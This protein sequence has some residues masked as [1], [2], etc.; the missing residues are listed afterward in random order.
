MDPFDERILKV[1]SD[2]KK[3]SFSELSSIVDFSHKTLRL[4]LESLVDRG[5]VLKE[6]IPRKGHGRPM[7]AYALSP[8]LKRQITHILSEPYIEFVSLPFSK[9]KHLCRFEKGG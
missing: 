7:F 1:L 9:H 5:L 4:R 3:R 2:G 8:T 6:K